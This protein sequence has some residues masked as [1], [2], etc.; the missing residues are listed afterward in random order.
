MP[1]RTRYLVHDYANGTGR[2]PKILGRCLLSGVKQ[3]SGGLVRIGSKETG[4]DGTEI[5]TD[6]ACP[7]MLMMR[8]T[9]GRGVLAAKKPSPSAGC[10]TNHG[11]TRSAIANTRAEMSVGPEASSKRLIAKLRA[12]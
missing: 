8:V 3:T 10:M 1:Q 5:E 11:T 6:A 2:Y 7:E 9:L 4:R 12:A